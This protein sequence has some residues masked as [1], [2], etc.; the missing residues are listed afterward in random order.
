MKQT[1]ISQCAGTI[2]ASAVLV[3]RRGEI[4]N[5]EPG[6]TVISARWVAFCCHAL[7]SH[8]SADG[9]EGSISGWQ[10][11]QSCDWV[12]GWQNGWM[13]MKMMR[14]ICRGLRGSEIWTQLITRGRFD[15]TVL[16]I[17]LQHQHQ[18]VNEGIAREQMVFDP[19][20]PCAGSTPY[21]DTVFPLFCNWIVHEYYD[22]SILAHMFLWQLQ[23]VQTVRS[24]CFTSSFLGW[25]VLFALCFL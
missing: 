21:K 5:L 20:G 19:I 7:D 16:T 4:G 18:S 22:R 6:A 8:C 24:N 23:S 17:T 10:C 25:L 2:Q 13:C 9:K 1:A 3:W 11:H 15:T 14:G 12:Q